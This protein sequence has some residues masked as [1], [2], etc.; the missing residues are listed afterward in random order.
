MGA[1][2]GFT[3]GPSTLIGVGLL[4]STPAGAFDLTGAWASDAGQ[5][6]QVFKKKGKTI[7]F[8]ELSD[9]HGSGFIAEGNRLRGKTARCTVKSRKEDGGT[10]NLLAACSTDIMLSTVQFSLKIVD[11]N[12]ISRI[13]PG[14][15]GME[16]N[17]YRCNL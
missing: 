12:S 8:A 3:A 16:I 1:F 10:L 7:T 5:C 14:M 17:Y 13:F 2:R 15:Q 11:D 9:L 6:S 4:L